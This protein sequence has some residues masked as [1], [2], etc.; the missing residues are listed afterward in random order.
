MRCFTGEVI[1]EGIAVGKVYILKGNPILKQ[2]FEFEREKKALRQ[3]LDQS[4]LEIQELQEKFVENKEYLSMQILLLEDPDLYK[5]AL[6][7][8]EQGYSAVEGIHK[9]IEEYMQPLS[10]S[11]NSY[12]QERTLDLAD[13]K[14]RIIRNLTQQKVMKFEDPFILVCE[15]LHPS[16]LIQ[17][18]EFIK[19]IITTYGGYNSHSAILCRQFN[20]PYMIAKL[21]ME[22]NLDIIL[23]TRKKRICISPFKEEMEYYQELIQKLSLEKFEAVPHPGFQFLANVSSN[24]ELD[25]VIEYGF[26]GIGLYRTEMIFMNSNRSY[27]LEEQYEI[28]KEAIE[29]MKG[30][31]V[32]FRTFDIGDD[33]QLSY[34]QAYKKGIDNYKHNPELFQ[35]QIEALL[36]ANQYNTL[37]IM[38]PMITSVEEF[39][40]LKQWVYQI[41][42]NIE[43]TSKFKLGIMLETKEALQNIRDFTDVDFISIGTNDL[44]YSIYHVHR[45]MQKEALESYLR[46]LLNQLK[47]V[48][49]FCEQEKIELSICGEL[50]AISPALREFIALGIKNFSVATPAIKVLNHIYKEFY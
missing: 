41:Q 1:S 28:Y 4:I 29:R 50:A 40:F 21:D 17:N 44:I 27:T 11:T 22:E 25:K 7:A 46:D 15:E 47:Q 14:E 30:K 37:K 39:H 36:K 10:I 8:L 34:V 49:A 42:R 18:R 24:I 23:D 33:K 13:I 5:K 45:N 35:T 32:C 19:G 20:I 2:P 38:F 6:F 31:S 3:A 12:L 9:V 26:D 16:F 43:D 48:I